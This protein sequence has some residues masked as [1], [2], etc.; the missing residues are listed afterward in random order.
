MPSEQVG[1]AYA[2]VGFK[3]D[4]S[5]LNSAKS[6]FSSA[7]GEIEGKARSA[8]SAIGGALKTGLEAGAV[9]AVGIAT[10]GLV[11]FKDLESAA[12]S[13]ASKAVDVSGK[14]A[15]EIKSQ[16]DTIQKHIM[17]ISQELGSSTIFNP[18]QIA[19][20]YD[21]LAAKGVNVANVGKT[22]LLPFLDLA[23]ATQSDLASVT[24]L[25][26]GSINSFGLSMADSQTVADQMAM[27][28]NGSSASMETLNYA[29]RQ[30]GSTASASGMQ[31]SEF[32][33]IVGVL[34]DKNYTGEQ[35][36]AALKTALLALYE[37]TKKQY[38]TMEKLGISYDQIDPRTHN[39]MDTIELLLSKGADIGDFGN[40]FTDSSGA[41]MYALAGSGDAVDALN[42]KI[43][44]SNGLAHTQAS[45]MMD[46]EKLTGAYNLAKSA[47]EGLATAIGGALEPAAV[48]LLN[49]WT[50]LAPAVQEFAVAL[51]SGD[52]DVAGDLLASGVKAGYEKIKNIGEQLYEKI[53]SVNWSGLG[54]Y[55]TG[56]ISAAW[57]VLESLG[58]DLLDALVN[59]D[60][61]GVGS[62]IWGG[63]EALG[64]WWVDLWQGLHDDVMDVDW[65]GVWDSLVSAWD[66]AIGKFSDVGKTILGY[67]DGVDWGTVGFKLGQA[68]RDAITK[69]AD[70]G[71]IVWNYLTSADWSGA[72]SSITEK[73]KGGLETLSAVWDS[74]KAGL[75]AVDWG[76]AAADVA[77]KLKAGW[78]QVTDW[79]GSII[80]GVKKDFND[81]IT[82]GG[83]KTLGEDLAKAVAEGAKALGEWIYD[84]IEAFWNGIKGDGGSLGTTIYTAFKNIFTTLIDWAKMALTAAYDF[85]VGFASTIITAGKGTIGAALLE[86]I[87]NAMNTAWDGAGD[88]LIERA[89]QW[90]KD[91]EDIFSAEDF[92]IE[93]NIT[94]KG[95]KLPANGETR[96]V[97]YN[98]TEVKYTSTSGSNLR[99]TESSEGGAATSTRNGELY[100][101]MEGTGW[102]KATEWAE[103]MGKAGNTTQDFLAIINGMKTAGTT[104]LPSTIEKL[105]VAFTKGQDDYNATQA[106]ANSTAV[107]TEKEVAEIR[108][109]SVRDILSEAKSTSSEHIKSLMDYVTGKGTATADAISAAGAAAAEKILT[110]SQTAAN[111]IQA[112]IQVASGFLTSG[113]QAVKIGLDSAGNEI[114]V[115]G[116]VAQQKVTAAGGDLYSKV[117]VAGSDLQ[118]KI[119]GAGSSLQ[120]AAVLAG[121]SLQS[122]G[123][124]VYSSLAS[125]ASTIS[126]AAASFAASVRASLP[127]TYTQYSYSPIY[128]GH[129]YYATGTKTSGPELAVIGEDGPENPE[130]VIPTKTKRWDLLYAAMRAYGLRGFAEGT[131]TGSADSSDEGK[132]ENMTATFGITG[133]AEMAS[134]VKKILNNL[135]D[136][137]RI[138]WD[139]I[140]GEG[141]KYWKSITNIVTDEATAM[142]DGAWS[143]LLDVR[144]TAISSN[145][146]ILADAKTTWGSYL[147]NITPS[148][149]SLEEGIVSSFSSAASSS[150][151]AIDAMITNST[152]S[153]QAFRVKW[154]EIWTGLVTDMTAAQA[155]ISA[156]VAAITT[157]L[158][159][160]S[161]NVNVSSSSSTAGV[162]SSA[163]S[164]VAVASKT[165]TDCLFEGFTDACTGIAVNAL[166]YTSPSGVVSYINPLTG[167]VVSGGTT[168]GTG[169]T[170]PAVFRA[171]GA[172]VDNGPELDI[173][174]E[175][176][177]ELILPANLTKMFLQLAD[178]GLGNGAAG[179][180][181]KIVI[182][183][184]TEHHWYLDGKEVTNLVMERVKKQLQLRGAISSR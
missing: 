121:S 172:L 86:I 161:V 5:G 10:A 24:D 138:T 159:K 91:A 158:K 62:A 96:D 37:P 65:S 183:D 100:I 41:I 168:S 50:G 106:K 103:E 60:W 171:K 151:T 99:P 54:S 49:A 179:A 57:D 140:K 104:L 150:K 112:G 105:T 141:A 75:L 120:S 85:A 126:S 18:T 153:M 147:A 71:S 39:F 127:S 47:T 74:F 160:I 82:G 81:W 128:T 48:K 36:G 148:L 84:K 142:R 173:V 107:A 35:S 145:A 167:V 118:S 76:A 164:S 174:G 178:M 19:E 125:G 52:W 110:G 139:I 38:E 115:I 61:G 17:D 31:L 3:V 154:N 72:G 92:E 14:S 102:M 184:C 117:I 166:K 123:S 9:A 89:T 51:A 30:G 175:S 68:I 169:Y 43:I 124:L 163:A 8:G 4:E 136:F 90:R 170:L 73:I 42:Q 25:V 132:A 2:T 80:D 176:G 87:G 93:A 180:S 97:T 44:G 149:T 46:S 108:K 109:T 15:E 27:A 131:S 63:V 98:V 83:P 59:V 21:V 58:S 26:T 122:G 162:S 69:L 40:I 23:A 116:S 53:K 79:A 157:E 94:Q 34:A 156:G 88:S 133:L 155:K 165:L 64:D 6:K 45:L 146:A 56:G 32:S 66:T 182:E 181:P 101:S 55:V 16:Y 143:A 134:S 144:N 20:T 28:M 113:G 95:D 77:D 177:P 135:K 11:A 12:S 114:A 1:S 111:A 7:I 78:K 70:I 137:F 13:A 152:A 129:T 29:L 67:F 130:F 22:E 33:A 119:S